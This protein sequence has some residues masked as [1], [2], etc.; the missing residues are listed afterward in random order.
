MDK[1]QFLV[2]FNIIPHIQ[3]KSIFTL[4]D[5]LGDFRDILHLKKADL[6][7]VPGIGEKTADKILSFPFKERL[8]KEISLAEKRNVKIITRLD[9]DYPEQ[10]KNIYSPPLVLYIQ[11][12]L[13]VKDEPAIAIVGTRRATEYGRVAAAR[14]SG[15]LAHRGVVIVSGMARGIDAVAHL[16]AIRGK[17]KTIGVMGSGLDIIYP[18]EHRKLYSQI[19]ENGAVITEFAF[20]TKPDKSNFPIRN[21]I[22][23]GLS[24]GT[25][26]IEASEKSGTLITGKYALEQGRELFAV[27]GNI[28]SK[29]SIGT[30]YLIKKGAKLIQ[31]ADDVMNEFPDYLLKRLKNQIPAEKDEKSP[32][33][34]KTE[35]DN[36]EKRVLSVLEFDKPKHIDIVCSL[37]NEEPGKVWQHLLS[38]EIKN[39]VVQLEGKLFIKR[40]KG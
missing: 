29:Q 10:L 17:G 3:S 5:S 13:P 24:F 26:I 40:F 11:G 30:N 31:R 25:L 38:L 14:I 12:N 32:V 21:R 7:A 27:P 33:H 6:T 28:T 37:L 23:S 1:R 20:G 8:E 2:A 34:E 16:A 4:L 35:L 15:D 19:A 22:I 9:E 36:N 39:A 18:S